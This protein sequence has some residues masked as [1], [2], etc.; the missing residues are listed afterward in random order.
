M[1]GVWVIIVCLY[2]VLLNYAVYTV[3]L[4]INAPLGGSKVTCRYYLNLQFNIDWMTCFYRMK[5]LSENSLQLAFGTIHLSSGSC[6]TGAWNSFFHRCMITSKQF[7]D[8]FPNKPVG[9]WWQSWS[10]PDQ[11]QTMNHFWD[12]DTLRN[13]H[14]EWLHLC[15]RKPWQP[16]HILR[17]HV[18]EPQERFHTSVPPETH[19]SPH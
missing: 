5:K 9:L 6:R 12:T 1:L 4:V 13:R 18:L 14:S 19:I 17:E 2:K 16:S 10:M 3:H 8:D 15:H 7:M 11:E